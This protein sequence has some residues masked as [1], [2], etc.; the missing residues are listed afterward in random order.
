MS[1]ARSVTEVLENHVTFAVECIDRMYL[2]LYVPMLQTEGGVAHFWRNHRGHTFASSALM[3]PMSREFVKGIEAF[4]EREGVDL[5]E[6]K[7][8][9]RKED[10]AKQYLA[11]FTAEEGVLFIGKAQEKAGVIRTIKRRNARTGHSYA[12]LSKSTA[13]VNQYYFYCIDRDFGPFFIKFSSYFP[14]NGKLCINGH[15]Y[16]KRQLAQ[17]GVAFEALDNSVV[18]CEN[19]E[20]AQQIADAL[21]ANKIDALAR[22]WFQRLPHPFPSNDRRAGYR[23]DISI[24]QAEFSLTQMLDRPLTGRIFFEQVIRDNLDLGRPDQVQ[25]I[26]DRRVTR[27]TPGRFRT[28]VLTEGVVPSLHIDYKGNRIKQYHKEGRALRTETTINNTRDFKIGK[29]L[30]NLAALRLVGFQ[31][32]RRLLDVQRISHD[33]SIGEDAFQQIHK[34]IIVHGQRAAG[35]RFGDSRVLMLL[36]ALV[37]FRLLPHGFSNRNLRQHVAGLLGLPPDQISQGRMSYDLR[38]LR[39]HGFI[40]RVPKSHRYRVTPFGFSA[41]LFLTRSY[42]RLLRHGFSELADPTPPAPSAL[43][44]VVERLDQAIAALL[45]DAA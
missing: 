27:R 31:A 8:G 33:C 2:N 15:E 5:V 14:Y 12:W 17:Q 38:R 23:Y 19:P 6:F 36:S 22:K 20:L 37:L 25:L 41:A 39:L 30:E 7:K 40:E 16:L 9:E 3:G 26:F 45:A 1:V 43:R 35:L 10:L 21:S 13:M 18:S 29:R 11:R 44:A 4:A 24:L 34:P 42:N 32:N 28:R